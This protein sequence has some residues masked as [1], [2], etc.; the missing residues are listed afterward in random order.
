MSP[1]RRSASEHT[2]RSR[3]AAL[4]RLSSAN[5]W[6]I[7]GSCTLTGLFT[8]LAANAFPGRTIAKSSAT[9]TGARSRQS[10]SASSLRAPAQ[11]PQS[12]ESEEAPLEEAEEPAVSGPA[13]QEEEFSE[14]PQESEP[15]PEPA[16]EP[17][18]V[19]GGS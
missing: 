8:A 18:I 1:R 17:V 19:S 10:E 12:A 2:P 3:N 11:A 14:A 13:Y 15:R 5:R 6:L 4:R 7:A 9:E 16:P